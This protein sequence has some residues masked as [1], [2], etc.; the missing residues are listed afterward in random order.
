MLFIIIINNDNDIN[1]TNKNNKIDYK[2][3][4]SSMYHITA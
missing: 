4:K 3:I 2:I 1:D